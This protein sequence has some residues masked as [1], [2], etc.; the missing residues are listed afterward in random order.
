[1]AFVLGGLRALA[2]LARWRL[3]LAVTEALDFASLAV[4]VASFAAMAVRFLSCGEAEECPVSRTTQTVFTVSG[5]FSGMVT[6]VYSLVTIIVARFEANEQEFA[7]GSNMRQP[8]TLKSLGVIVMFQH[9]VPAV[10]FFLQI[11]GTLLQ[12][13]SAK[14]SLLEI[15]INVFMYVAM[16]VMA[17]ISIVLIATMALICVVL[18]ATMAVICIVL[19]AAMAL[20]LC[21]LVATCAMTV[22]EFCTKVEIKP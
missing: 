3:A 8:V 12:L 22:W 19:I 20:A 13:S 7:F 11:V 2:P 9:L 17:L 18:I 15:I 21:W 6:S 14:G 16:G 10:C 5:L 1:M 4:L